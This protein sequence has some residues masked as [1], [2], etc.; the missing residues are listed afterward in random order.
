MNLILRRWEVIQQNF[1][2]AKNFQLYYNS[3]AV[4][5]QMG[6]TCA[7]FADS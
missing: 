5:I 1:A 2:P 4:D 6:S 7:C 3:E